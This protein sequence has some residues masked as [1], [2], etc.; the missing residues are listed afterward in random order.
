M[1]AL[2]KSEV[3]DTVALALR[4]AGAQNTI[5]TPIF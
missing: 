1:I 2:V 3:A 5:I 4:E